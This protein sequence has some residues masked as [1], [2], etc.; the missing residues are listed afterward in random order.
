[1]RETTTVIHRNKEGSPDYVI[2]LTFEFT[3]ESGQ[4]VGLCLELGTSTFASTLEQTRLEL[5]EAVQ[6]QLNEIERLGYLR[7]YLGENHVRVLPLDAV[8]DASGFAVAG[9]VR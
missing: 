9:D 1:M 8:T 5:H 6:L 4:W 3:Q 2:V 7:D